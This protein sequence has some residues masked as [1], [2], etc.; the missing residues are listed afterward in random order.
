MTVFSGSS[1]T[2]YAAVY[3]SGHAASSAG[4][5]RTPALIKAGEAPY[6]PDRR[7]DYTGAGIDPSGS[8]AWVAGECTRVDGW[9]TWI[10]EVSL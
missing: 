10:A 1:A 7:A 2:S 4:P 5:F 9:G 6:T 8:A 3:A